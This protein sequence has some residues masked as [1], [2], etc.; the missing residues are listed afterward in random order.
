MVSLGD[1]KVGEVTRGK[2]LYLSTKK[3]E[4]RGQKLNELP[5]ITYCASDSHRQNQVPQTPELAFNVCQVQEGQ[6]FM[7]GKKGIKNIS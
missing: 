3:P 1:V 2:Q 5:S 7:G 6:S 4:I